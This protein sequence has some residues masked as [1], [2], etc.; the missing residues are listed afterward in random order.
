[1]K[2]LLVVDSPKSW[3]IYIPGIEVTSARDY[4]MNRRFVELVGIRVFNLCKSY[5]YQSTGYYVSLLAAARGHK[6]FP[7]ISAI[8][9]MKSPSVVRILTEEIDELIQKS[10]SPVTADRFE[11]SVYFGRNVERRYDELSREI[12]GLFSAPL[13]RA[14]FVRK[15]GRWRVAAINVI[16]AKDIPDEHFIYVLL[17]AEKYF[18]KK[19]ITSRRK[20]PRAYD[21]AVLA[22][23]KEKEP[24]SDQRALKRI[25]RAAEKTGFDVEIISK[26]DFSRL[27]EFDALFIRETT[28][29]N[30]HTFQ[31]AQRAAAGGLAVIDDPVS[32]IRCSNKVYLAELLNHHRIRAPLT[33]IINRYSLEDE[34]ASMIYPAILKQPD[35]SFSQGVVKVSSRDEF[36]SESERLLQKSSLI[37][38]QEFIPTEFD[39]RIGVLDRRPLFACKYYMAKKHWQV[40]NWRESKGGL[41]YGKWET[42]PMDEVPSIVIN[43]AVKSASLIGDGL[44]GVDIK[45]SNNRCYVIEVNDNPNLD[46]GVEDKYLKNELYMIIM[47]F[48]E[49]KVRELKGG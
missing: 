43:A 31:F 38:A 26:G 9:E 6:A 28:A 3:P 36:L 19:I 15:E 7:D 18:S 11:L 29:V 41:R 35:S 39:W 12:S 1:M 24:P 5:R 4:L 44:Y 2:V 34:A 45:T 22:D 46:Y 32:I 30:H 10:L 47:R 8:E 25:I 33:K 42:L 27:P 40:M 20:N 14:F 49:R 13:L 37:I 17:F 21:M 23:S 48:F 16:S